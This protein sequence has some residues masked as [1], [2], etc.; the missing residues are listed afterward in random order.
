MK[1]KIFWLIIIIVLQSIAVNY[2]FIIKEESIEKTYCGK[3]QSVY[4]EG[5]SVKSRDY[6]RYY[7]DYYINNKLQH[8]H[9]N[10]STYYSN[11]N[12]QGQ[13]ICFDLSYDEVYGSKIGIF[14]IFIFFI[15][16]ILLILTIIF[17]ITSII[18]I[19]I[20]DVEPSKTIFILTLLSL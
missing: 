6:Q 3:I 13:N 10:N 16:N 15:G 14:G 4:A 11:L 8:V 20:Y 5:Y 19:F 12:R 2:S 18:Q 9:V 1:S 7:I 17:L